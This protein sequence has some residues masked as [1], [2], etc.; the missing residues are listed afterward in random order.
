M[1]YVYVTL[2]G[3]LGDYIKPVRTES[4]TNSLN[5]KNLQAELNLCV[6]K[7]SPI[8]ATAENCRALW[9][10]LVEIGQRWTKKLSQQ[11]LRW[12][13]FKEMEAWLGGVGAQLA[14]GARRKG[15][16]MS[17]HEIYRV[18]FL[19]ADEESPEFLEYFLKHMVCVTSLDFRKTAN[20]ETLWAKYDEMTDEEL[21]QEAINDRYMLRNSGWLT[22]KEA[23]LLKRYAL[24]LS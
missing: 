22:N 15:V 6:R 3:T 4:T 1:R 19:R 11:E 24:K 21:I 12:E 7:Y 16:S 5:L 17:S 20:A 14:F 23:D 18:G 9:E 8:P 13:K 2:E 10:S